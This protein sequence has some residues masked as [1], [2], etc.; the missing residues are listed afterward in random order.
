MEQYLLLYRSVTHAQRVNVAL[1]RMGIS[2]RIV[3]PPLGLSDKGCGYA[4]RIDAAYPDAAIA[5]LR[6]MKLTPERVYRV[7]HDGKYREILSL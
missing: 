4:V 1:E 7:G 6:A 3:R 5:Q 2:G